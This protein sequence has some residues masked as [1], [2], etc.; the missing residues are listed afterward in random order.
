V[1]RSALAPRGA[2]LSALL[3]LATPAV[4]PAQGGP[5]PKPGA[6][7]APPPRTHE[8]SLKARR[9]SIKAQPLV[10]WEPADSIGEALMRRQG[11]GYQLVRYQAADVQFNAKRRTITLVGGKGAHA[12]V[13]RDPT[14][15]VSDTIVYL[16]SA[17]TI[18]ARGDS[19]VMRD[20]TRGDDLIARD[21]LSYDLNAKEGFAKDVSGANKNGNDM[22]Y[23]SAHKAAFSGDSTSARRSTLYGRNG[24]ITSCD[25]TIP[26][27]HF[28]AKEIKRVAGDIVV[29]RPAVLYILDVPVMWFPFIFQDAREGRRTG[30][31][32]PRFG[33]TE[34]VRNSPTYRRTVENMGYYFALSDY[35]DFATSLDWRSSANATDQDPGWVRLN[36]EVRYRWINRFLSGRLAVSQHSLSSGDK[37]TSLSWS[38]QQDFSLR[39]RFTANV[40]YVTSTTVQR[41]TLLN[42][43]AAVS[44]IASQV[45]YQREMGDVSMSLGGTR[46]QYPGRPQVDQDFPS[47]NLTAKPLSLASWLVWTPTFSMSSS[48]SLHMDSQGDFSKTYFARSDG[49]LDSTKV[50]RSTRTTQMSLNTPFKIFGFQVTPAVRAQDRENDFPELRTIVDPVDTSKKITRVYQRTYLSTVDL[51]FNVNMPS[52]RI[53]R[54]NLD[55]LNFAPSVSI[56]NVDPGAF[57]VRSE[58]TGTKWVSQSKRLSYGVSMSPTFFGLFPGLGPVEKLRHSITP[59]LSYSYSPEAKVSDEYLTALGRTSAGYLGNLAQSR[60]TLSVSQNIEAKLRQHGDSATTNPDAARKLK[61]LSV[62]FTPVTW[63]FEKAKKSKSGFATDN[64]GY[65]VRSDLLPG[66]DF[67]ADYSLFQ[68][69]VLSDTAKFSP[70]LTSIRASFSLDAKSPIVQAFAH[71]FASTGPLLPGDSTTTAAAGA[72]QAGSRLGG[73]SSV[74]GQQIRGASLIIPQGRGFDAQLTFTKNQQRPPVGGHVIEYDPAL[75]C[76]PLKDLNPLQYDLC[77]RNAIAAPPQDVSNTLTTAGGSFIRYPPQTNIQGRTSFNLTPKWSASWSTNYDVERRE[78]G[79]QTV[80]LQ[81]D[82]HDWRAAFG[83]TQAPNGNFAF[84]FNISLKAEPDVKFDYNRSSYHQQ[85]GVLP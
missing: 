65:T 56:A 22:W 84:T 72:D 75:Q 16:D 28:A 13:Q 39:S 78:F 45:N 76:A 46:R 66:F 37:N 42:P 21:S 17:S 55:K 25:D 58:R 67:G 73:T 29:A 59:I 20:P 74:A 31:L 71:L 81:R 7:A 27:Y 82:L 36:G 18:A 40:N 33:I 10:K 43:L 23:V 26:H 32:T 8:D 57:F 52:L 64:V 5:P 35:Y 3:L 2:V 77:V 60:V 68:G 69:S 51:D 85:T 80:S 14:L 83:F 79:S 1:R 70:Y 4:L 48:Q 44:T 38:H 11:R 62:T 34:L 19:I 15:L 53:E 54:F 50:D 24:S 12:A 63:D 6:P 9:D 30:M 61:V 47:L 49:T 41:Q